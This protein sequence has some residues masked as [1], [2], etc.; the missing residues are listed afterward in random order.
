M[1]Q[2]IQVELVG[3]FGMA[4]RYNGVPLTG[5]GCA[6]VLNTHSSSG[7]RE[8]SEKVKYRY[9]ERGAAELEK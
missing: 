7:S 2:R 6:S 8:S 4:K 9:C 1:F 5:N 3:A